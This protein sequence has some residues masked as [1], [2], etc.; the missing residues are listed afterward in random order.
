MIK[1]PFYLKALS[2]LV[3]NT[4]VISVFI[5]TLISLIKKPRIYEALKFIFNSITSSRQLKTVP[6]LYQLMDGS[7]KQVSR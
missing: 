4:V 3:L 1:P 2:R 5:S 6:N 7:I